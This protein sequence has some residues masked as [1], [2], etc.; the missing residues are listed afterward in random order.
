VAVLALTGAA[1][2]DD[3]TSPSSQSST[4]PATSST[5]LTNQGTTD[6]A[7]MTDFTI[8]MDD[9]YFKPTFIKVKDGQKLSL[10]LQNEG[11]AQ[12]T[13]TITGLN[14]DQT[15]DP[16]AKKDV[17]I[18]FSGSSDVAF[19]CRFHGSG[20]MRGAFF[21]G[22]APQGAAGGTSGGGTSETPDNY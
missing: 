19:F 16:G 3:T 9:F 8:E 2:G 5:P 15:I 12:H 13:F 11:A 4:P 10:E 14:I 7:S 20:G 22:S 6:A 17:E 18:T 1:C 21:F